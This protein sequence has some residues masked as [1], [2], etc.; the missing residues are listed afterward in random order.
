MF[1]IDRD[2]VVRWAH[3][4]LDYRTRPTV[5]QVLAAIDGAIPRG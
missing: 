1:L 4:E 3:A 2:G 5:E